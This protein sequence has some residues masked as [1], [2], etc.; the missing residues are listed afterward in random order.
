MFGTVFGLRNGKP[1][2][3]TLPVCLS[4]DA[5]CISKIIGSLSN[6]PNIPY[7]W[8][9]LLTANSVTTS[10]K[11]ATKNEYILLISI[12][13]LT[14]GKAKLIRNN[15]ETA[16]THFFSS[17]DLFT[18]S[19]TFGEASVIETKQNTFLQNSWLI[20]FSGV[21]AFDVCTFQLSLMSTFS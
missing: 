19:D 2:Q 17:R 12:T 7:I 16:R 6:H 21:S 8:L 10:G 14:S 13:N 18:C 5:P 15:S 1:T 4:S 20:F 9:N 11:T 3:T